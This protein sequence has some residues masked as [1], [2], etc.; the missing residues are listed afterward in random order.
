MLGEQVEGAHGQP[1]GE[2]LVDEAELGVEL[3]AAR[4]DGERLRMLGRAGVPV[5]NT[6]ADAPMQELDGGHEAGWPGPDDQD[7]R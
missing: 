1:A 5:D 2:D 3:K 6:R 7:I 4:L